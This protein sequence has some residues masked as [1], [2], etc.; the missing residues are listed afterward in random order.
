M[1]IDAK[2]EI[3][4]FCLKFGKTI[5]NSN[6][7][8]SYTINSI[9]GYLIRRHYFPSDYFKNTEFFYFDKNSL[10]VGF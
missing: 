10:R 7:F 5:I 3:Q 6:Y 9:I 2:E 4:E 1:E 8:V